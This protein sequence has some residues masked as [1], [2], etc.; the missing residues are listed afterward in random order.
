M[1]DAIIRVSDLIEYT[2]KLGHK[3]VCI[4]EHECIT[5]HINAIKYLSSKKNQDGWSDYKLILGNEIYLCNESVCA[6]N[7][8][9]LEFPHFILIALDEIGHKQIRELSTRAWMRAFM[10]V[11]M[12]VPTYY[13][14]L[15]DI[16]GGNP[17]HVV[18]M[19]ACLGGAL[20]RQLLSMKDAE[21]LEKK[22]IK[23]AC[24]E[25]IN[26]L[27]ELF[28]K[29]RFFL[30]L[31]PSFSEEQRFVNTELVRLAND[32][33]IPYII[34]TDSHYLKFAD[35][36]IHKAFVE[37]QD[38]E[39]EADDFYAST[40]VMSEEEIHNY[41]DSNL[42]KKA[43]DIGINNSMLVYDMVK[44]YDLRKDLEIPYVPLD[45]AEPDESLFHKYEKQV[46]LFKTF[47]ES[48]AA[49]DR[50]LVRELLKSLERDEYLQNS[51][52][53]A[54]IEECLSYIKLSS[55]KMST[56]WSRYLI[57]ISDFVKLMWEN[58]ITVGPGRGSGVG[59]I[60]LYMLGI[61]QINPLRETTKTYPWRFLNPER[62]SVLDIDLDIPSYQNEHA[63]QVLKDTY[64][65]DR[66]SKVLT[67][68][69]E[70][71]RSAILTAARGLKIDNDT[72]QY[73]A[74][75]V[76]ADRGINRNLH[77][78]YYGDEEN[79]LKRDM[80]FVAEMDARPELWEV[81]QKIEG[82]INGAGSHAGGVILVDKPFTESTALMKTNSGDIITQFDLHTA[83]EVSLI[84]VDLLKIEGLDKI[85]TE[86]KLLLKDGL[87]EWQGTWKDT[88]EKY[89]GIYTLE[90]NDLN[91][92]KMLW[93]HEV[94]SFF[95]MEKESGI[96]AIALSKPRSVDDLA[97]L[98]SVMRLMAQDKKAEPPLEKYARFHDD[99]TLWYQEMD[100]YQLAKEEQEILINI[101]GTS[102]GICEAQEYLVL[103]TMEPSIGGFSL[104]WGDRLRRAVAKKK[105]KEFVQLQEEFFNNQKEKNLSLNLCKYT[106]F[107]LI[108]TQRGYGFN[109]SHTLAYSLIGLQELNLA[110]KYPII[111]WNTAN[112]IVDSGSLE[113]ENDTDKRKG[114]KYGKVAAAIAK[115]KSRNVE[116]AL[117]LINEAEYGFKPDV[118]NNRIIFGIKGICG[119]GD[120][121]AK[122][123]V[124][125]RPYASFMDFIEKTKNSIK[126]S[127]IIN[128]IKAGCFTE[129]DNKDRR[130][131]MKKFISSLIA[132]IEKLTLS[133]LNRIRQFEMLPAELSITI[134]YIDFKKYVLSDSFL[135]REV[136]IPERK[137]P[138]CGYHDRE[139]VLDDISM[140]F[141]T[142]HFS[143][144]SVVGTYKDKYIV[145][146][147]KFNKEIDKLIVPLFE[148]LAKEST[149]DIYNNNLFLE[150]W[151]KHA[152]GTVSKWE[153]ESLSFY[154]GEHEL[155]NIKES[156]YGI[157]NFFELPKEPEP[158]D[159]Y[160]RYIEGQ[161]KC[162]PKYRIT[163]LAGTVLDTDDKKYT[164]TLLTKYGC[165]NVKMSKGQFVYYNK[166]ISVYLNGSDNKTK[167]ENSWF[168]RGNK[169]VVC[170]Y[171]NDS[172]FRNY[173]YADTIYTHT[174]SLISEI[175][176]DGSLL[177]K[178]ERIEN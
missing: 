110:F 45:V 94:M 97:T 84:K 72:A 26:M 176:K 55:E 144:D 116:V 143:E 162:I 161:K 76:V 88:Y 13:S 39:R 49:S 37:S 7:K 64:G 43:V 44:S 173:R 141:F 9:K 170:G 138:K 10:R 100:E 123:I 153:M 29:N 34:T 93:N 140:E 51:E 154:H 109:R 81:A 69:T 134:R 3:G 102:Y 168:K 5:S 106:W 70:G 157:E 107:V 167:L 33:D 61:T 151:N 131:T 17:G 67:L 48:E 19:T 2:H 27:S 159:Y 122:V 160:F 124:A 114:T 36:Q 169:I 52:T 96:Q 127:H 129:I 142:E 83:E 16:I 8:E 53:Y 40:Y 68:N 12:R 178:A 174:V 73:I 54:S 105:P 41:L 175:K 91:M 118:P 146:E 1:R 90:R 65:D 101:L 103:L 145:S 85:D 136:V 11:M 18:G 155:N 139:F 23:E 75:M 147:K 59:F 164:V 20:P 14:D 22:Q 80:N 21:L 119:V 38:G 50:H 113:M 82:L 148:W 30:E 163:R 25:W 165:V 78:M 156:L 47:Y 71:T 31:Q 89:L 133:Q 66:V 58:G 99:I 57:Q 87:I 149:I 28:G 117:P 152:S 166:T 171:R 60:L 24:I 86:L 35:R 79:D 15:Y 150:L 128:L 135:Y 4:T 126:V 32:L 125:E 92:W 112:L 56:K 130:I 158:Y 95:Q 62:A 172:Y 98:N 120:D 74:S 137:V 6:E 121:A 42:G 111:Y 63:L 132:P 104:G 115:I 77:Q 177:L 46:P 108:Y